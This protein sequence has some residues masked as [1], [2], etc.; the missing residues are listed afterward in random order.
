[1]VLEQTNK[2][3]FNVTLTDPMAQDVSNES[4][5]TR[6]LHATQLGN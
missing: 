2:C 1:M 3:G 4:H 5:P 6:C